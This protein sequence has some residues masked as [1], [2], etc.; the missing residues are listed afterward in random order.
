[1]LLA[2][3]AARLQDAVGCGVAGGTVGSDDGA[4]QTAVET[5]QTELFVEG[6][7]VVAINAGTEIVAVEYSMVVGEFAGQ[8]LGARCAGG[9]G[10]VA[11]LAGGRTAV[12]VVAV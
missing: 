2:C 9:T 3:T 10:I 6:V 1:M 7:I 5:W 12:V 4:G 11:L 8:T